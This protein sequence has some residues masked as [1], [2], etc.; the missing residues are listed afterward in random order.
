MSIRKPSEY[1]DREKA[2]VENAIQ[3]SIENPGLNTFSEAYD[4]FKRNLSKVDVLSDFSETL[5]NYQSNIEKVNFLSEKI[6][7]IDED[8]KSLLTKEDLDKALVAQLLFLEECIR[9]V[10]DKVKTINQKNLIQIRLDVSDLS[11]TVNTFVDVEL[12]KY[13]KLIVDSEIKLIDRC[14][15][16]EDEL[17]YTLDNIKNVI[18]EKH[19]EDF[20]SLNEEIGNIKNV[21]DEKHIEDFNS[22]NEEINNIKNVIDEK[23]IEDFNSLNEEIGNIKN[24]IDEK[25]IEDF[26]NINEEINNIKTNDIPKYKKLIVGTEI[27]TDSKIK[28][29]TEFLNNTVNDVISKIELVEKDNT[30]IFD[31]LNSKVNEVNQIH[32]LMLQDIEKSENTKDELDKKIVDLE[33]EILKNESHIENQNKNIENIHEDVKFA[34]DKLN[35][36]EIEENNFKLAQKIKYIEEVFE[37]FNEK[38]LLSE[39]IIAEPSSKNNED[40]LTPLDKNFVTL[41]ELQNHYKIFINRIQQQLASLGGGG[42]VRLEFLDDVDRDSAKVNGKF[43]KY[44]SV[45]GKWVG[46]D[47]SGGGGGSQ[48]L[49]ETLGLGNTSTLG[50]SVGVVTSTKIHVDPVGSGVTYSENLV[51]DGNARV[52]GI[53]S[54]G[55]SSIVLDPISKTISGFDEMRMGDT[56]MKNDPEGNI[57]F[58]STVRPT[59]TINVGIGT[60]VSINTTGIITAS[61]FVGN[62]TGTATTATSLATART[63]E[64]TGDVVASQISFDGTGN[65]SLA[66]TIQPNSVALGGDTTGDYVE[67]IS[68]TGNQITVT[69][70]TGEGSTPTISIPDNPT[71]PGTTVTIANDLQVNRDLHVTGNVTI[72]GTS[73]TL[74]SE[75]LKISD[76]DIIVGFRTDA[77]GNDISNDTTANHGGIGL[78]STEGSPLVSLSNGGEP[79]PVT[80]KKIMWFKSGSFTG[81]ATDAWLSNYAFGVGTTSMS[82]GTKFA[83]GNIETD[84]DDIKSVRHINSTGIITAS[85]FRGDGSQLTNIISGV[86]IQSGSVRVGTGFTDLKFTGVGVTIV[87]SGTTVTIDFPGVTSVT[88]ATNAFT[89]NSQAASYYLDYDNFSNTPTVPTNTNQLTNGAGFITATSSGTG[90]TGIVTSIVAGTNVTIS[91]STGVVTINSSGGGGGG[92]VGI[93][94]GGTLIGTGFTTLNFVGT[95]NTFSVDGTIVNINTAGG[96][97][98]TP[99]I[100]PVMMGMIF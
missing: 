36:G 53:L 89:L 26:N 99:D 85:S 78:A 13:E 25:Y 64:L 98:A 49:D 93:Q 22:L 27:K 94:S 28:E 91:G 14:E 23:H 20:N 8:I 67:S 70:G 77:A 34:I 90:L 44:D 54:I 86:G 5:G 3:G 56:T 9:D 18:D 4:A 21:I 74:F 37:K 7:E 6:D 57:I 92:G 31:T 42:E 17:K 30:Q 45:S 46:A 38:E 61:E 75:T 47:A 50:M 29:F 33:V 60:T 96:G 59:Q 24:V 65:V 84:F 87:G 48:T 68:G 76:P 52:T 16:L 66:A 58:V 2:S 11:E 71:L 39:N 1:F 79:L 72:G 10:Q 15:V 51:V 69:A 81:L 40:T 80:Y 62:L 63:F 12:P 19:I 82:A 32:N 95:G 35:I 100:S 97:S 83:V 73:A 41:E 43:L 88:N 55:T